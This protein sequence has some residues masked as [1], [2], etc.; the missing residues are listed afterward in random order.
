MSDSAVRK[1][2]MSRR[3]RTWRFIKAVLDP[4]A[5][6]HGFKLLNYYNYTHVRELRKLHLGR[7]V[8]ISPTV[9]FANGHNVVIG[10]RVN[11]GAHASLWA[12]P[13][14]ARIVLGDDV[15]IAPGVMMTATN[16]RFNDGSPI[17]RQSLKEADIVV[18]NDVW[19]GYGAVLLPGARIGDGAIV[20]AGAVVRGEVP[21]RAIVANTPAS[22]VGQRAETP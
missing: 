11:V 5:L 2:K 18:G 10:N 17:T 16:Y 1:T 9:S 12:G 7:H 21:P 6:A 13:D 4:R 14:K 19:I 3:A 8:A 22:V 20:G 15:L